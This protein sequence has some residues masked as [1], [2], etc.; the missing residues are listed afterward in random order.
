MKTRLFWNLPPAQWGR[1]GLCLLVI[2]AFGLLM[3][4]PQTREIRELSDEA[5]RL[6][7]QIRTQEMLFP[8]YEAHLAEIQRLKSL[9]VLPLP[10]SREGKFSSIRETM[11]AL[12]AVARETG[13]AEIRLTPDM[14]RLNEDADRLVLDVQ[15]IGDFGKV[16]ELF[17]TMGR[18][19][20]VLH[21]ER[22]E[23]KKSS[24]G[25]EIVQF[26]IWLRRS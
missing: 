19:P 15:M 21:F 10:E 20:Y 18:L 3:I 4:W 11:S 12:R 24:D 25:Q 9:R 1:F 2:L 22:L 16:R 5:S 14:A 26:R 17:L 13:F 23:V 7:T 8:L 6:R